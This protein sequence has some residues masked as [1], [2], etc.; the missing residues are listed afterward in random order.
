MEKQ[1][2]LI[3]LLLTKGFIINS[4]GLGIGLAM[5]AFSVSLTN[6]LNEPSMNKRRGSFIAGIYAFFQFLMPMLG[7]ILVTALISVFKVLEG[8]IPYI[9]LGLLLY[10]GGKMLYDGIKGDE[11]LEGSRE[12]SFGILLMQGIAT[13]IDALS[14]GVTI[15][16]YTLLMALAAAFIIGVVTFVVCSFG[17]VLG[18]KFGTRLAGSAQIFGGIILILIGIEI[19][20]QGV[21]R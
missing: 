21:F 1:L 3:D 11:D 18:K 20:I 10:I 5:D 6:G 14:V 9:A 2:I 12:L 16:D 8:Y 7:W 17:I 19:F 13:S 4:I 15:A